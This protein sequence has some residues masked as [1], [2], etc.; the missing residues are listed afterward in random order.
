MTEILTFFLIAFI[1]CLFL[2]Y[3]ALTVTGLATVNLS[4]LTVFQ[5][6]ILLV[7][8][9]MGDIV[10]SY[11][12]NNARQYVEQRPQTIVAWVMV[13]V[14]L[15][16]F[17]QHIIQRH[18]EKTVLQSMRDRV[19]KLVAGVGR[20]VPLWHPEA[21]ASEKHAQHGSRGIQASDGIGAALAGG[22]TTG[23]GLGIALGTGDSDEGGQDAN[24]KEH[25]LTQSRS[26]SRIRI[27]VES[28]LRVSP[29]EDP[30]MY[31][32][33]SGGAGDHRGRA[34]VH[35]VAALGSYAA[36]TIADVHGERACAMGCA[37]YAVYW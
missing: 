35:V 19:S 13:L 21:G 26:S 12:S 36:A 5:Q 37:L 30:T 20:S 16:Y 15:R 25:K 29:S 7:L 33:E 14:R 6:V 31:T 3:S 17:R 24:A 18:R 22:A 9:V 10:R 2:C 27:D 4:T 28:P 11:F 8:M 1:D 23:V 32:G 34:V